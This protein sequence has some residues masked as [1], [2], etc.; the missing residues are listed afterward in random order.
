MAIIRGTKK[1]ETLRGTA[2]GDTITG[3]AGDDKLFGKSGN[4]KLVGGTGNDRLSG[5]AGRD[6]L[7]G[8]A[9]NDS[10]DGGTGN[11]T[12]KGGSGDDQYVVDAAGDVVIES[13][14]GGTDLV[15]SSVTFLLGAEVE[16]L[17]LTGTADIDG[18][19]NDLANTITG[20]GGANTLSGGGGDDMLDGG[21]G[22][23]TL[24]GGANAAAGDTASYLSATARVVATLDSGVGDTDMLPARPVEGDA[25]GDTYTG[26]EN[27]TGSSFGDDLYGDAGAN[28][29]DGAGGDDIIAGRGGADTLSGGVGIDWFLYFHAG[30]GGDAIVDFTVGTDK[31]LIVSDASIFY[32]Q[33]GFRNGLQDIDGSWPSP[34][35]LDAAYFVAD[36]NPVSGGAAHG[37][38]LYDTDE[39]HLSWDADGTGAG[40]PLLL[41]TFANN[42]VLSHSDILL[43]SLA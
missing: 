3:L 39:F 13:A 38:F 5:G 21:A 26:I 10:L 6:H 22:A 12:M 36:A 8:A 2:T 16:S 19:G 35:A 31:I 4:D 37:Y 1:K 29:I 23:D 40:S 11:D 15:R 27:L 14:G 20:N 17:T 24:D 28:V 25:I 34:V 18:T 30:Q 41:A 43:G 7:I 32:F 42:A 33:P 9:G